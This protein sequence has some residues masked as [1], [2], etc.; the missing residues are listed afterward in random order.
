MPLRWPTSCIPALHK[1]RKCIFPL[2]RSCQNNGLCHLLKK[3]LGS[4]VKHLQPLE[5][6]NTGD[7]YCH[8][9]SSVLR[10]SR[11]QIRTKTLRTI[12]VRKAISFS[13]LD[14]C[15]KC[16]SFSNSWVRWYLIT[17][18]GEE[19]WVESC[20]LH[21]GGAATCDQ[22]LLTSGG[23]Q[24]APLWTAGVG[25]ETLLHG[26]EIERSYKHGGREAAGGGEDW[27]RWCLWLWQEAAVNQQLKPH[28]T[29][30]ASGA[31]LINKT[32]K[33]PSLLTV[34]RAHCIPVVNLPSVSQLRFN[35]ITAQ[36]TDTEGN[37]RLVFYLTGFTKSLRMLK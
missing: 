16:R 2:S 32:W 17:E 7:W 18:G 31:G 3:P 36:S 13:R 25:R 35:V 5:H 9:L 12:S 19:A 11:L 6:L 34:H 20:L 30:T 33:P 26:W 37:Q 27:D 4:E 22:Q 1:N 15:E 14:R 29:K 21:S 23:I 8:I 28:S 24:R 10:S